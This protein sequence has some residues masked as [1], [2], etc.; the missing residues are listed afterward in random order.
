MEH[1]L[2]NCVGNPPYHRR[3]NGNAVVPEENCRPRHI[4]GTSLDRGLSPEDTGL[5]GCNARLARAVTDDLTSITEK[6]G[7]PFE[8]SSFNP[9]PTPQNIDHDV[10]VDGVEYGGQIEEHQGADVTLVNVVVVVV[11][12]EYLY[13]ASRSASNALRVNDTDHAI[14]KMQR[15]A[16]SVE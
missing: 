10:V 11:V 13:S 1:W 6:V 4:R 7:Q 5:E 14:I 15:N 16:V 8:R 2:A 3:T 12:V 9:K